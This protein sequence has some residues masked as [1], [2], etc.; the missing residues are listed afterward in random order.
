MEIET[1][2][3]AT[4]EKT[5]TEK[6]WAGV[7]NAASIVADKV[8]VGID[9]A[10]SHATEAAGKVE[11]AYR[12]YKAEQEA[13]EADDEE[14]EEVAAGLDLVRFGETG[15]YKPTPAVVASELGAPVEAP[16]TSEDEPEADDGME[17]KMEEAE[18]SKPNVVPEEAPEEEDTD[19]PE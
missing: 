7:K 9:I 10:R 5:K 1:E 8:D 19:T 17:G 12:K 6:I 3:E 15:E 2:I 13:G 4:E 11:V 14:P 18:P 16:E